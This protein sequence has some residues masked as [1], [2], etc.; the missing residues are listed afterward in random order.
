MSRVMEILLLAVGLIAFIAAIWI[1]VPAPATFIWL[2]AVAASEWSLWIGLAALTSIVPNIY[3]LA[4]RQAGKLSAI[5]L[6]FALIALAISLYPFVST[7]SI[8]HANNVDLSLARYFR[9][10]KTF[11]SAKECA[12]TKTYTFASIDG[13]DL[14]LDVYLTTR[15]N[16]NNGASVIVV[17]GGSW[18]GGVRSDFPEWN[19]LLA[20][21]GFTVFD[22]DYR[23]IPQPNYLTATGDVKCAVGWVQTHAAE[24]NILPERIALLGRSAGAH[25]ALLA[26]YS[27]GDE[28]LPPT[29]PKSAHTD[30]VR[31]VVSVYAPVE[32]LWA[33]DNPANEMVINGP[34]TLANFLGGDPHSS[35]EVRERF[36]LA[37]PT[38]HVSEETPPTLAI[39]GG[40]DQLVRAENLDFL[41][42][43]LTD[44]H[45]EHQTVFIPYAQHG[46]DYN[47]NGWGSQITEK[48]IVD[49]LSTNTKQTW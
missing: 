11:F 8:A 41:S 33:Y 42:K 23:L 29:C 43:R 45:V 32:L 18:S 35:D 27:A 13:R 19:R 39:H 48:L 5:S 47:I 12:Q 37:S 15:K 6:L 49:F 24:F 40:H 1:I 36:I 20:D 10:V 22:I 14:K 44:A 2:F 34:Q 4:F 38:S 7:L 9:G 3:L 31:A 46:Y 25:L 30:K 16:A 17:H 26:A 21:N 28:R